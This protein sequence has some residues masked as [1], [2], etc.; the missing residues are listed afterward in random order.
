MNTEQ[1]T[2]A[3]TC[4]DGAENNTMTFPEV[5][6]ALTAAGFESY[7]VDFRKASAVYFLPDGDSLTLETHRIFG[8][9]APEF[10]VS[11]LSAAICEAQNLAPGYTYKGFCAKAKAAGCAAYMVSILGK[12]AVYFGRTGE[13]HV[14]YFP[15]SK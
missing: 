12:R 13:T 9:V 11:A 15:G 8:P 3:Q 2:V 10:N 4:K 6:G 1:K 5:V 7:I 14:E